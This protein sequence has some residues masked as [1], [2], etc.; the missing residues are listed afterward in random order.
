MQ[1]LCSARAGTEQHLF[2]LSVLKSKGCGAF[3][4]QT[5]VS[6]LRTLLS[7][8]RNLM[9]VQVC[10]WA[11][12]L[13]AAVGP[14]S[15]EHMPSGGAQVWHP[16]IPHARKF[17]YLEKNVLIDNNAATHSGEIVSP[18]QSTEKRQILSP[19]KPSHPKKRNPKWGISCQ[20]KWL[21]LP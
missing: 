20:S 18:L 13:D 8:V 10:A 17:K 11:L 14:P 16:V 3:T 7:T 5:G 15:A 19:R 4:R 9:W 6:I 12:S 1:W 21:R 2:S